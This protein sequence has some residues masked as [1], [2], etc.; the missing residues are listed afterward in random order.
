MNILSLS[1]V[2]CNFSRHQP[3]SQGGPAY[4]SGISFSYKQQGMAIYSSGNE[5][6]EHA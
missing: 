4:H 2:A 6:R 5:G 1:P 3:H